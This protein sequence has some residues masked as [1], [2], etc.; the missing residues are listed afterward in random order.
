MKIEKFEE[1]MEKIGLRVIGKGM[2]CGSTKYFPVSAVVTSWVLGKVA[3]TYVLE[4]DKW[5]ATKTQ[6]QMMVHS[7]NGSVAVGEDRIQITLRLKNKKEI[8]IPKAAKM[9]EE[10]DRILIEN[11]EIPP[12][13]C[14]ICGKEEADSFAVL[15]GVYQP[16]HRGCLQQEMNRI[17]EKIDRNQNKG[18]YISGIIGAILGMIVGILPSVLSIYYNK[19]IYAAFFA[20]IPICIYFGYKVLRGKLTKFAVGLTIILSVISVYVMNIVVVI[21]QYVL[22]DG[23]QIK[24]AINLYLKQLKMMDTWIKLTMSSD[25]LLCFLF[26]IIGIL[27]QWG[28]I[29]KTNKTYINQ[30]DQVVD[31][32]TAN[33]NVH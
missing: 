26:I 13:I 32:V 18:S 23:I 25:T 21:M 14:A 1:I 27:I 33:P 10:M 24:F 15:K 16:V 29:T 19:K 17:R 22:V 4:G 5:K 2:A 31:T 8:S 9:I 20:L 6:I 7:F 30:V 11:G 12:S 28:K 3:F